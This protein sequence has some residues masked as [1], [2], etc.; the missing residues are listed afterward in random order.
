MGIDTP[1]FS[2]GV[3]RPQDTAAERGTLFSVADTVFV[4][5]GNLTFTTFHTNSSGFDQF[6]QFVSV[7]QQPDSS[8]PTQDNVSLEVRV[9][10]LQGG[11]S[12]SVF[13]DGSPVNESVPSLTVNPQDTI[14]L[15]VDNGGSG[16]IRVE[17][18]V[19]L[20]QG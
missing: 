20:R 13:S 16:Q 5:S 7:S 12:F 1:A 10:Q 11:F 3:E 6:I 17:T 14:Q 15:S 19:T 18:R 4:Q 8:L 9:R 2:D